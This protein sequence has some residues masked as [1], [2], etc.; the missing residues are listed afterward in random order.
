MTTINDKTQLTLRQEQINVLAMYWEGQGDPLYAL[1]SRGQAKLHEEPLLDEAYVYLSSDEKGRLQ[2]VLREI[3]SNPEEEVKNIGLVLP[4]TYQV[5][6]AMVCVNCKLWPCHISDHQHEMAG[7]HVGFHHETDVYCESC[8]ESDGT[9]QPIAT[10]DQDWVGILTDA[11]RYDIPMSCSCCGRL[12]DN[13]L[14]DR[15]IFE[16]G[17]MVVKGGCMRD[18]LLEEYR[19]EI[20]DWE[21]REMPHGIMRTFQEGDEKRECPHCQEEWCSREK[22]LEQ[23]LLEQKRGESRE[24]GAQLWSCGSEDCSKLFWVYLI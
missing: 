8:L 1:A 21:D 2:E 12:I 6:L 24:E 7:A 23:M 9:E 13:P 5:G 19:K 17:M 15:G 20:L 22:D 14:S 3:I 4:L 16:A 18:V 10:R 11:D